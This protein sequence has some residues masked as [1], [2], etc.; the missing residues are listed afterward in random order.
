MLG[1]IEGDNDG[2]AEL[3]ADALALELGDELTL[4]LGE[5]L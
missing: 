4:V 1:L 3:L 5:M 2:E